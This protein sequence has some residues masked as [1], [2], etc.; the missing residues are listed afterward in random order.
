METAT[1]GNT[2]HSDLSLDEQGL[3]ILALAKKAA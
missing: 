3:R 1:S 2:G